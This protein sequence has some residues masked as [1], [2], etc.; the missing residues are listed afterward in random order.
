MAPLR[1][2]V[3]ALALAAPAPLKAEPVDQ[4]R[5]LISQASARFGVPEDWIV[6]VMQAESRG[7]PDA[8]SPKGAMGLM[9]L[10]PGTWADMRAALRLGP[11]PYDPHD[12]VVAGAL[13][14][15]QLYN[16]FGYPG[17]FAAYNAGP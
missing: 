14:L 10:M 1:L 15:R 17:L 2:V 12:N 5:P 3:A 6:R 11:D 8:L 13:Y 16:R 9:Q 4:W 7:R